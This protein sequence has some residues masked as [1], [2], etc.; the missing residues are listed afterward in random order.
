MNEIKLND[1]LIV[2]N[3][4]IIMETIWFFCNKCD[5]ERPNFEFK[6]T[7]N[8][9]LVELVERVKLNYVTKIVFNNLCG[10]C[11]N[12]RHIINEEL[13]KINTSLCFNKKSG[14]NSN[15]NT[16]VYIN[17]TYVNTFN[18]FKVES[19]NDITKIGNNHLHRRV[20]FE[21]FCDNVKD[22]TIIYELE[23]NPYDWKNVNEYFVNNNFILEKII[24]VYENYD[25]YWYIRKC[26]YYVVRK[27]SFTKRAVTSCTF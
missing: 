13:R 24:G 19:H 22:G 10:V 23:S 7:D 18:V 4:I 17:N 26:H 6:V 25:E 3:L 20:S 14:S 5:K 12:N 1:C 11:F 27:P 8:N 21:D 9:E 15:S 2:S 16:L